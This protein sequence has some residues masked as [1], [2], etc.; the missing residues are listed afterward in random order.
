MG[1]DIT[2]V[3]GPHRISVKR[4]PGGATLDISHYL[5][6]I[7]HALIEDEAGAL[8][9]I[10]E[11]D[12]TAH[13]ASPGSSVATWAAAHRD[14]LIEALTLRLSPALPVYGAQGARLAKAL[15][16]AAAS[17]GGVAA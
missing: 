1:A 7:I 8:D 4:I 3:S 17:A 16:A 2:P 12:A 11:W 9:E 6:T 15:N 14:E 13:D 5:T 10:A